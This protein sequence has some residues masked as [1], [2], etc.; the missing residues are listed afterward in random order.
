MSALG[1]VSRVSPVHAATRNCTGDEG[2]IPPFAEANVA[3][4]SEADCR[5]QVT[6]LLTLDGRG[7][8]DVRP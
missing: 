8:N 2:A 1:L 4:L 7:L 6:G 3:Q 5:A